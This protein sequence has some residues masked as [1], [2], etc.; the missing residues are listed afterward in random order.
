MKALQ[1]EYGE[2]THSTIYNKR[3]ITALHPSF[4]HQSVI[5]ANA[6]IWPDIILYEIP[7]CAGM[8]D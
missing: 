1:A 5:P 3:V 2:L 8:T 4:L 6:G 7:A